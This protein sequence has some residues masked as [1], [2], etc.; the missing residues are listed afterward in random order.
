[1]KSLFLCVVALLTWTEAGLA[2][3]SKIR[4]EIFQ[5]VQARGGVRVIVQLDVPTSVKDISSGQQAILLPFHA[6]MQQL[7][8][9]TEHMWLE[10]QRVR[11]VLRAWKGGRYNR[12]PGLLTFYRP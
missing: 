3:Q 8:V 9:N 4:P 12:Y 10:L 11:V 2:Q 7:A 5:K 6:L 1:M